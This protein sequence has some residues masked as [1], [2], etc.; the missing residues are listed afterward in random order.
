MSPASWS[1]LKPVFPGTQQEDDQP[2]PDTDRSALKGVLKHWAS[3]VLV[4]RVG[5]TRGHITGLTLIWSNLLLASSLAWMSSLKVELLP[6]KRPWHIKSEVCAG[7]RGNGWAVQLQ[8]GLALYK[9]SSELP[10]LNSA[11]LA[12]YKNRHCLY[13]WRHLWF[14]LQTLTTLIQSTIL[15]SDMYNSKHDVSKKNKNT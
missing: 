14:Q 15:Y 7:G 11:P 1:A 9:H 3:A 6:R 12:Q 10:Q 5:Q 4:L 2:F 13:R 8:P